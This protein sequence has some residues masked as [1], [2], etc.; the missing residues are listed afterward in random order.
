MME[1]DS[2]RKWLE[3]D[4]SEEEK[5]AFESTDDFRKYQKILAGIEKLRAPDFDIEGELEKFQQG[6]NTGVQ[7]KII[8]MY[9]RR[10]LLKLAASVVVFFSIYWFFLRTGDVRIETMAADK[11]TFSLPDSSEVIVNSQS[12]LSYSKRKWKKRREVKLEGEAFFKVTKGSTFHVVTKG[13]MVTVLGTQFNVKQR[14]DI[15]EVACFEG[16]VKVESGDFEIEVAPTEVVRFY[17]GKLMNFN[18][19]STHTTPSWTQNKSQFVS[20]PYFEVINEL[21]RQYGVE[22]ESKNIDTTILFTGAFV[23]NDLT[24][25]LKSVSIPFNATFDDSDKT[26]IVIIGEN[27]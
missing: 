6:K 19:A 21:K 13:G 3:G 11:T 17:H 20:L 2:L 10:V 12:L 16:K 7:A 9:D 22:I 1:K 18:H 14:G 26:H 25:A 27:K 24:A 23:H 15:F 8:K 4:M 5:K